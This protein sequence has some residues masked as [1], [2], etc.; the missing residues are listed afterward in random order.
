MSTEELQKCKIKSLHEFNV[1]FAR[2]YIPL[3][4]HLQQYPYTFS[5]IAHWTTEVYDFVF[6]CEIGNVTKKLVSFAFHLVLGC[7]KDFQ[8]FLCDQRNQ[9][10]VS[11]KCRLGLIHCLSFLG[12]WE[13]KNPPKLIILA[14]KPSKPVAFHLQGQICDE[15]LKITS[16]MWLC[17]TDMFL[18]RQLEA[19]WRAYFPLC[20][21]CILVLTGPPLLHLCGAAPQ[22]LVLAGRLSRRAGNKLCEETYTTHHKEPRNT[23]RVVRLVKRLWEPR[24][25]AGPTTHPDAEAGRQHTCS[26]GLC[27]ST[28]SP[29]MLLPSPD[30]RAGNA[31]TAKGSYPGRPKCSVNNVC[32]FR[33]RWMGLV[34]HSAPTILQHRKMEA[35][36]E[37]HQSLL[38]QQRIHLQHAPG[39]W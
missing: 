18:P 22:T 39:V 9:S 12:K 37:S 17:I 3:R 33:P 15:I 34:S 10:W 31:A 7:T 30:S 36:W 26:S 5:V 24:G 23:L 20:L 13:L 35:Y 14:V 25:F 38:F 19:M 29:G 28:P 32:L 4:G 8:S 27:H 1:G 16:Q 21:V 2:S 6:N 11:E